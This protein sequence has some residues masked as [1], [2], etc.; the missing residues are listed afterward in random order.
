MLIPVI[1][2]TAMP[3]LAPICSQSCPGISINITVNSFQLSAI[4]YSIV[5]KHKV[6]Y[7]FMIS[8]KVYWKRDWYN[9]IF[10]ISIWMK[11]FEDL[12]LY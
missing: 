8:M 3:T 10:D 11:L 6:T 2:L 4:F 12:K 5:V 9:Q 1:Y 7:F